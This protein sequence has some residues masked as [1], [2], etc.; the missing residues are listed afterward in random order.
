MGWNVQVLDD[1]EIKK[2]KHWFARRIGVHMQ[3]HNHGERYNV[4]KAH[5]SNYSSQGI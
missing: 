3:F 4:G 2:Y 5:L 1:V